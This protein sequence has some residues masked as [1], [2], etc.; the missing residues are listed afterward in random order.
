MADEPQNAFISNCDVQINA[1]IRN[2]SEYD[3]LLGLQTT[4]C[5]IAIR[6]GKVGVNFRA[7]KVVLKCV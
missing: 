4:L 1:M 2:N 6:G 5:L 7:G 3:Q